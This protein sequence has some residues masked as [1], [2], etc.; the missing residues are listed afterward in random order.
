MLVLTVSFLLFLFLFFTGSDINHVADTWL[1][2]TSE[3]SACLSPTNPRS[4]IGTWSC[5]IGLLPRTGNTLCRTSRKRQPWNGWNQRQTRHLPKAVVCS[6]FVLV[7]GNDS[8]CLK[9][10]R[11]NGACYSWLLL[12]R[13]PLLCVCLTSSGKA[14]EAMKLFSSMLTCG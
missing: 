7:P 10:D 3:G 11:G 9:Q 1:H 2:V 12:R 14:V 5:R 13:I 6:V 8:P 4:E